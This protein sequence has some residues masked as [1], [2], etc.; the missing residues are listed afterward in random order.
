MV[1]LLS[2]GTITLLASFD[3]SLRRAGAKLQVSWSRVSVIS[4][5]IVT[6]LQRALM[7]LYAL[8]HAEEGKTDVLVLQVGHKANLARCLSVKEPLWSLVD[9]VGER[10]NR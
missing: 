3:W 4:A 7:H 1:W 10:V 2:S 9:G 5:F 8:P 6:D